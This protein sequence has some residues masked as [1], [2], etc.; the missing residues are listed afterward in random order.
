MSL[1]KQMLYNNTT[2]KPPLIFNLTN[3][4]NCTNQD[5]VQ[6]IHAGHGKEK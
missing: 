2:T 6:Q 4:W 5:A 3:Q 1:D